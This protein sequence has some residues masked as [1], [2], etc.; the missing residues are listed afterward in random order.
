MATGNKCPD[1][2]RW[3]DLLDSRLAEPAA[4]ALSSHLE[5][6]AHCQSTV[7]HLT[8]GEA[9]WVD[10]ARAVEERPRPALRQAI[11]QL[12]AEGETGLDTAGPTTIATLP[13][14]R[15]S[16]NPGHLGRI[17]SYEVLSVIGRGGMG[18]VLRAFD[19]ALRRMTA[20]KVLAPQWASHSQARQRFAREA[21]A[22]A[23]V[24]HDNVVAIHA[25]EEADGL[26]YL[27]MEFVPGASLQQHLDRD[28]PLDVEDIL[29]I[30]AQ[31]A[32]GL[33]AAHEQDLIHRDIKPANIL[34][35]K[36]GNVRLT[37]FGL[38]RAVDDSSLTQSGV[39]AGTPQYMAPEQAR[40]EPLDHR[41]DL[42]SLG[43]VLYAMC[44]GRAPF[45]APTT[46][47][48]L[49]RVCEEMPRDV[50]D[51][52]PDIP[53]WLAEIIDKLH[54][55]KPRD[56]F[57]S[58]R[59]VARLLNQH[60]RHLRAPDTVEKPDPVGGPGAPAIRVWWALLLVPAATIAALLIWGVVYVLG[61]KRDADLPPEPKGDLPQ[62]QAPKAQAPPG[63]VALGPAP[64]IGGDAYF[65][66]LWADLHGADYFTRKAAIERLANMQPND[67]RAKVAPK[68][69]E[70]T[71]DESPFI[72]WP[73]V[74]ALG[75]WGTKD[76]LPALMRALA[77]KDTSTRREALKV[78]GRFRDARTLEP[79]IQCFRE[80]S[81]RTDAGQALRAMGT[82]SEPDVLRLLDD[83]DLFLKRDAIE[84]L[85]DIGTEKSVP[86]LENVRASR[87]IHYS[88]HLA[89]PAEKA[90]AAIAGR[91]KK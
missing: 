71:T 76:D 62:A 85:T 23:R 39:I 86:A 7:E 38:A 79:V 53:D 25:V 12:K 63:P 22:A 66:K 16:S 8:A 29:R 67:Q 57:Q 24:R 80:R 36:D 81:T 61:P 82:M 51:H 52:N 37:D 33:A 59:E 10:A 20:I 87:D 27:V 3:G 56:R 19:P 45:R 30:G 64:P 32:A 69:A 65:Q 70:L 58:A 40:G 1:A 2:A 55:K 60:L 14:L 54:A 17:G 11:E 18:V 13:F 68:L 44:T 73:A 74:K 88:V 50:R 48:V 31:A 89:G 49:K 46:V 90:L 28:E 77:H 6:C 26:P 35:D 15:P 83:D 78:I 34:L 91:K 72:R 5:G 21:R 4:N 84:V 75:A 43:S 41:A 47:A 42:F 9:S